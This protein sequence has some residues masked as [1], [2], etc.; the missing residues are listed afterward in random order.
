MACSGIE[1]VWSRC[2]RLYRAEIERCLCLNRPFDHLGLMQQVIE[3]VDDDFA[4]R[5]ALRAV[6]DVQNA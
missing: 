4:R 1:G 6:P 5:Q 2:K 3:Q